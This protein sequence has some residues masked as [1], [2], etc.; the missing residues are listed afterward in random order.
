MATPVD[1]G[2]PTCANILLSGR[3]IH[4]LRGTRDRDDEPHWTLGCGD[5]R[6]GQH[7]FRAFSG[8]HRPMVSRATVYVPGNAT[9]HPQMR[10]RHREPQSASTREGPEMSCAESRSA[11]VLE[12]GASAV[13]ATEQTTRKA[14]WTRPLSLPSHL[15]GACRTGM[16]DVTGS[17]G[18]SSKCIR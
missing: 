6:T 13:A 16:A 10:V 1:R 3:K 8:F 17:S 12:Q 18:P 4:A 7:P 9:R 11:G 14:I 5:W 2:E 15:S